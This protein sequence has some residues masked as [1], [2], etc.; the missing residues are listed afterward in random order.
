MEHRLN[1]RVGR[2]A[3]PRPT[4]TLDSQTRV[5]SALGLVLGGAGLSEFQCA[6][7]FTQGESIE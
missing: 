7:A 3:A 1:Q 6:A 4:D 2:R 5:S